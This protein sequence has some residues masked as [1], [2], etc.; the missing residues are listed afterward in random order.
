MCNICRKFVAANTITTYLFSYS[1]AKY[2]D[3][4]LYKNV[5]TVFDIQCFSVVKA[6]LLC[7]EYCII[8]I[9]FTSKAQ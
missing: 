6:P 3:E 2:S 8:M 9:I 7:L 1:T 5:V 4:Y